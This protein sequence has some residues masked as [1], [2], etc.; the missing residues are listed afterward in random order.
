ML[1]NFHIVEEQVRE[2]LG[3]LPPGFYRRLPKLSDGPL[4][5]YPR[6][7]GIA[8][9][10][11]AHT[12]SGFDVERLSRYVA[13]Y[14]RVQPLTIGELWAIA[15]TLRLVLVE[16]LRRLAVGIVSWHAAYQ[17][18]NAIADRLIGTENQKPEAVDAVL[19]S[20]TKV[21]FSKPF[22]VQLNQQLRDQAQ[23]VVPILKWLDDRLAEDGTN[24]DEIV[25]E[26]HQIQG[27]TNLT[28]R[29]IITSMR[30]VSTVDWPEFVESVGVVDS[31]LRADSRF[32]EMDFPTRDLYRRTIEELARGSDRT[33][34]EIA[35][36]VI[37]ATKSEVNAGTDTGG[38]GAQAR[39]RLLPHFKRTIFVRNRI[40]L[41]RTAA[42]MAL[43]NQ[44]VARDF[45]ISRDDRAR[46]RGHACGRPRRDMA[47][48]RP[49]RMAAMAA[50]WPRP[51]SYIRLGDGADQPGGHGPF[52]SGDITRL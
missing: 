2:I 6:V 17:R 29:N 36:R 20:L 32:S 41:S 25:R 52:R 22:A 21:H 46:H 12:D 7:F 23:T 28:V 44:Y 13:A 51:H 43:A 47:G 18:A 3:D 39:S 38:H 15:I 11:V 48:R 14:Q 45:R 31:A 1:D 42:P 37:A 9:D 33:E 40:G 50:G 26:E 5:G 4:A 16:N 19:H 30:L 27:A 8:W 35:Q 34:L 49:L 24:A 10:I